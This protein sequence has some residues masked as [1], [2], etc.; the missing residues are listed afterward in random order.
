MD[1]PYDLCWFEEAAYSP[2]Q[3]NGSSWPVGGFSMYGVDEIG[4]NTAAVELIRDERNY[5]NLELPCSSYASQYMWIKCVSE[6][7]AYYQWNMVGFTIYAFGVCVDRAGVEMC[8]SW[9][10]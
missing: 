2:Y 6:G 10:E 8:R 9:P 4:A 7:D 1:N 5:W 3:L